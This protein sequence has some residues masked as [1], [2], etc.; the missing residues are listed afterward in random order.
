MESNHYPSIFISYSHK[1]KEAMGKFGKQLRAALFRKANV[2]SD[3]RIREGYD[4]SDSLAT[5]FKRADLVLVLATTDYLESEWCRRELQY[6]ARKFR[7]KK[8]KNLFWVL[9]EPCPWEHSELAEFQ[10]DS[11][12]KALSELDEDVRNRAILKLAGESSDGVD[13]II[14]S[15][16]PALTSVRAMLGDEA[17]EPTPSMDNTLTHEGD[18]PV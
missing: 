13:N 1:N 4:S 5:E 8:I 6:A 15:V 14:E 18:F 9:L 2:W 10:S 7:E 12:S 11:S 17:F 3:E 16:T